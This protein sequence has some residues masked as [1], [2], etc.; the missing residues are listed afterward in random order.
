[1]RTFFLPSLEAG[2]EGYMGL[3]PPQ[4]RPSLEAG[5]EGYMGGSVVGEG[6]KMKKLFRWPQ[7]RG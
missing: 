7:V 2:E 3:L 1:M 4:P 6:G 5:K